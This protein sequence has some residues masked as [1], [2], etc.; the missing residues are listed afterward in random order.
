LCGSAYHLTLDAGSASGGCKLHCN[1][2][3]ESKARML[4]TMPAPTVEGGI[5][6]GYSPAVAH[7]SDGMPAMA[8]RIARV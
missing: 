5:T 4:P 8:L 6:T 3:A 7:Q 2:R 1:F